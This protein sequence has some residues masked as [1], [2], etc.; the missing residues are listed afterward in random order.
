MF[1]VRYRQSKGGL[2]ARVGLL[3]SYH[4]APPVARPYVRTLFEYVL[5]LCQ[6]LARFLL[7]RSQPSCRRGSATGTTSSNSNRCSSC[8]WTFLGAPGIM[9]AQQL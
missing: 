9:V 6:W 8:A 1:V 5:P 3:A 4:R 2:N 7:P